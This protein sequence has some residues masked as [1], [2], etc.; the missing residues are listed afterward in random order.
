MTN[1]A[2]PLYPA[3]PLDSAGPLA[4]ATSVGLRRLAAESRPVRIPRDLW[5]RGRRRHRRRR[6]VTAAATA[7]LVVALSAT[8]A[9]VSGTPTRMLHPAG[10]GPGPVPSTL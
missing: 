9:A 6:L 10:P 7:V 4:E 8:I 1:P 3:E 5:V 2:G